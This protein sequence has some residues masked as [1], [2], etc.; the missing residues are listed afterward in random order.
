MASCHRGITASLHVEATGKYLRVCAT[1]SPVAND[2]GGAAVE[3]IVAFNLTS[4][5]IAESGY[6]GCSELRSRFEKRLTP[7]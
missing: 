5:P 7:P 1:P 2:F 3:R 6:K 4:V